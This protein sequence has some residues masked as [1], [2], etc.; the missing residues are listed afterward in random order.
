VSIS[1]VAP[2]STIN[3]VYAFFGVP[4]VNVCN[5][6]VSLCTKMDVTFN[7]TSYCNTAGNPC[8]FNAQTTFLGDTCYFVVKT[9]NVTYYCS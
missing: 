5:C 9:F 4:N 8:T 6:A 1:C 7:I 2:Q 3:I